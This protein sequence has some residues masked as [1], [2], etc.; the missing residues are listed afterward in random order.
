VI[1]KDWVLTPRA[2]YGV[3]GA[4]ALAGI[5]VRLAPARLPGGQPALELPAPAQLSP[6]QGV[7]GDERSYAPI[8][9]ANVFSQTRTPPK[10]RFVPEG[11]HSADSVA[12]APKPRARVFRLYGITVTAKEATAL[13]DANPKIPGAELY[14]IGDLIGGAPIT[15]ITESTVVIRRPGG[16]LVL[17][18]RPAAR[19]RR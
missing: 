6:A 16:P 17:R 4:L 13:I 1:A 3:A 5:G 8:A 11:R 18:L 14:R 19:P 15:A 7:L 9:A 10:V 12:P 2:L